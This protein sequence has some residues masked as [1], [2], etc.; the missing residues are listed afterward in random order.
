[1]GDNENVLKLIVVMFVQIS[2]YTKTI[3]HF[4]LVSWV[5]CERGELYGV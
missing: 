1:M 5:V 2:E 3:M 4:K